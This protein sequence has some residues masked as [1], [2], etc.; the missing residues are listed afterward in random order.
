MAATGLK[1]NQLPL[2]NDDSDDEESVGDQFGFDLDD[3]EDFVEESDANEAT[4]KDL[5]DK[6]TD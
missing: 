3:D 6:H 2:Q 5:L 4:A 1:V